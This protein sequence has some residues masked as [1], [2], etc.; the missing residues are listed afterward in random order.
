MEKL[1]AIWEQRWTKC[2]HWHSLTKMQRM[3][4]L[5]NETVLQC[6]QRYGIEDSMIY[7]FQGWPPLIGEEGYE[8]IDEETES[9]EEQ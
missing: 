5:A 4:K 3:S 6:L 9:R 8:V 2:G 1:T 7:L